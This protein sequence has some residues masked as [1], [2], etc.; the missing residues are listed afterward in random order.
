MS[1]LN[2][3][4]AIV[5]DN[6]IN[7]SILLLFVIQLESY[8]GLANILILISDNIITV[9]NEIQRYDPIKRKKL[10]FHNVYI[11]MERLTTITRKAR[12]FQS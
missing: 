9:V 5:L 11:Y 8:M 7:E 10:A 1:V 4:R 2:T 3:Y 12:V 6:K